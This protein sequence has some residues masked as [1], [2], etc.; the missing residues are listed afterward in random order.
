MSNG[1]IVR[2]EI[3]IEVPWENKVK[4]LV[5]HSQLFY[6]SSR[7]TTSKNYSSRIEERITFRIEVLP[8]MIWTFP[9]LQDAL[10]VN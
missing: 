10:T 5:I 8:Q 1:H 3:M 9:V 2:Q 4:E 6:Y 7:G